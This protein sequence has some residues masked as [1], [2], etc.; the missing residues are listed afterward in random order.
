MTNTILKNVR[1]TH[2]N[3]QIYIYTTDTETPCL[4]VAIN[5]LTCHSSFAGLIL[6]CN[7]PLVAGDKEV[8]V[9]SVNKQ[10][11]NLSILIV[12]H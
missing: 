2:T 12:R 11:S 10:I 7:Y 4:I 9:F 8:T 6:E 3:T 1:L 5:D